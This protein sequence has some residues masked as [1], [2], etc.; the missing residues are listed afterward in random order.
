M[1]VTE[2]VAANIA[3]AAA[4]VVQA[5]SG[6]GGGFISVPLLAWID[7]ALVPGPLIFASL[8]LSGVMTWRER[9]AID[10]RSVPMIMAGTLPGCLIGAYVLSAVPAERLG[11]VFGIT[12]IAAI[13][14]TASGLRVPLNRL[15]AFS[16]ATIAGAMGASTGIGAPMIALL[17]QN[18]TGP[19]VR[20]TLALLYTFASVAILVVLAAF[21]QFDWNGVIAGAQL[22]PG[23]MLG[24][25][26]ATRFA[27]RVDGGGVRAAVMVVSAVAATSLIVRSLL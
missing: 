16:A 27:R 3:V 9:G 17:Y 12:I 6:I 20:S 22:I 15:T 14:I 21:G 18:E 19:R 13:A 4:S 1:T 2:F 25:W 24:Y 5:A 7:L 10:N 23:F 26:L 8:T 11:I